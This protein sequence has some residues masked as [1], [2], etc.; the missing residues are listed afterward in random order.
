MS[1]RKKPAASG[2]QV[3]ERPAAG[4]L[5]PHLAPPK[6]A[7][8]PPVQ[9]DLPEWYG[10]SDVD[11]Q[12]QVFL[13]TAAKS[14]N[15]EKE[16]DDGGGQGLTPLKDPA[17]ISKREFRTALQDSIAKPIYDR[18]RGGR[19]P[20][21]ALE[22]DVYMGVKEGEPGQQH[23]HAAVKLFNASHRFLPFKLAMRQR[24]GIATHWSTSHRQLWSTIRYLHCTTQ[25]KPIVDGRPE[26]WTRDGR[27]L[28]LYEESQ[29]PYQAE[30]WNKK[31]ENRM[32]E[33]FA[34]KPKKGDSFTKLDFTSLVLEHH[35]STPNAVLEYAQEK[36]AK[37]MQLWVN[38]RQRKLKEFIQDALD[39]EAAKTAASCEKETDWDLVQRLGRET[40][41]CGHGGCRWWALACEFFENNPEV[42]KERL[43]A[44]LRKI[45]CM[46]P[47]RRRGFRPLLEHQTAPSRQCWTQA[48]RSSARSAY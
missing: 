48:K 22:L 1:A 47:A 23:H 33:P 24:W 6:E 15:A 35:L 32:S 9:E 45:I 5:Q 43:A 28:N 46:V 18:A 12:I 26:L 40:C 25:H 17:K 37:A 31:R 4:G 3:R 14:V 34:K 19:P 42:D 27:K 21:R 7:S 11:A 29:E 16:T 30:A 10:E 36:G 44:S 8:A 20:T 38:C 2:R 39:W 13:V 41:D